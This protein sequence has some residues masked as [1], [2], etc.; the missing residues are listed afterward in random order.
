PPSAILVKGVRPRSEGDDLAVVSALHIGLGPA[1]Q[2]IGA[3][4]GENDSPA[5][6][7]MA[8]L[9]ERLVVEVVLDLPLEEVR[10]TDEEAGA[11]CGL[12]EALGPFR[13]ARVADHPLAVLDAQGISGRTARV[14]D[15]ERGH[16][17]RP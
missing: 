5:F 11:A 14:L 6:E 8:I 12:D 10:L 3:H 13:V 16:A 15:D 9:A 17:G 1:T 2:H 4:V 7:P